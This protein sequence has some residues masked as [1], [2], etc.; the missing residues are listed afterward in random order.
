MKKILIAFIFSLLLF[1][2]KATTFY[3]SAV[4]SDSNNGTS[5]ATPWQTVAKVNAATLAAG[6]N[7]LFRRGDTFTGPLVLSRNGTALAR[8]TYG[9]YGSGASPIITTLSTLSGWTLHSGKIYKVSGIPA[10]CNSVL[11][12]G[13]NIA[14]G[15]WPA[16]DMAVWDTNVGITSITDSDLPSSPNYTGA[17]LV[18]YKSNWT[19]DRGPITDHT[20]HTLT[21]TSGSSWCTHSWKISTMI[22]R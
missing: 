3:V 1:S 12:D 8:V 19:I 11:L 18:L 15:H 7:I 14:M 5:T 6:D 13:V 20:N 22:K 16:G 4:G 17:E 21:Y 2:G 9:A 10:N